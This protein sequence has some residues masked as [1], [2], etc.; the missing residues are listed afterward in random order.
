[1]SVTLQVDQLSIKEKISIMEALW[2][3]LCQKPEDISSPAWHHKVLEQREKEI[4]DGS[5]S[6]IDWEEAKRGI[7]KSVE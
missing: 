4:I 5:D 7:R 1:M 3:D 2:D 6:F